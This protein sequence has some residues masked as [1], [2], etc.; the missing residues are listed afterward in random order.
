MNLIQTKPLCASSSNLADM[1]TMVNPFDFGGHSSK[2]KVMMVISDKCW[3]CGDAMRCVVIFLSLQ[4]FYVTYNCWIFWQKW[5]FLFSLDHG[6][7]LTLRER[8]RLKA[9]VRLQW[10]VKLYFALVYITLYMYYHVC[11]FVALYDSKIPGLH[12]SCCL[13]CEIK[14]F[15]CIQLLK[16]FSVFYNMLKLSSKKKKDVA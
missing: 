12:R 15:K 7:K 16:L 8:S 5:I 11:L 14:F 4:L 6:P 1:L 9:S 10:D 2:V 3:V 13:Y